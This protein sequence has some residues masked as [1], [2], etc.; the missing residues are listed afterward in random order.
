M[1]RGSDVELLEELLA[2]EARQ[3][4][5]YEAA[6]RRDAVE[7]ALGEELLQHE[8]EHVAA[9]ERT[10]GAAERNPRAS[11]PSPELTRALR[12]REEFAGYALDL[13]AGAVTA[14]A[15][16]AANVSDAKLRQPLGSIMACEAAHGVALRDVLGRRPLVD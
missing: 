11:V 10:L 14:Y 16:A 3:M 15:E 5:A 9:L 7:P 6:L 1:A 8:R 4:A 13:E 12:S 2:L